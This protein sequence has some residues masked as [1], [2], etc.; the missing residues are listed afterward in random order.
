M[1]VEYIMIVR[2]IN[3]AVFRMRRERGRQRFTIA[4]HA[5]VS[6]IPL[7]EV[8]IGA[9]VL[10]K[11]PEGMEITDINLIREGHGV[12]IDVSLKV[13]ART[14]LTGVALIDSLPNGTCWRRNVDRDLWFIKT[15]GGIRWSDGYIW[16]SDGTVLMC[17]GIKNNRNWRVGVEWV[18]KA[19][20]ETLI[21]VA[22]K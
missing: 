7:E 2:D 12:Y 22:M 19:S 17:D 21:L 13:I 14:A 20:A 8:R 5:E 11:V 6:D 15:D 1:A 9:E 3:T 4:G 10:A 18:D 16:L